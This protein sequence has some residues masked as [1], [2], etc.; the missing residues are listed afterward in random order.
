MTILEETMEI[1]KA[2]ASLLLDKV[3]VDDLVLGIF[4]TGVKL[5]TGHGGVAFTPVGEIPE[6]VCCP[7]TAARMPR[8]GSL[9]GIPVRDC[10]PFATEKNVLKSAIAV[11]AINAVTH[12]AL[13]SGIEVEG[14][15][16]TGEDGFDLLK[17]KPDEAIS[18]IGAFG[19]YIRR[20]KRMGNPFF[21]VE[22]NPLSLREEE[23]AF[24]RPESQMSQAL[25][26]SDVVIIT[27]TAIVNQTIDA[28]VGCL[29]KGSRAAV[30]GPTASMW[31]D[32]FFRRGI[33]VM[34]GI[35]ILNSDSMVRILKE[36]G[37]A[38]HLL[39]ECSEKI[40]FVR[41]VREP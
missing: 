36:G 15:I 8:A 37:S 5:S 31:P 3:T 38:Y 6:A 29:K 39:H 7:T 23:K 33:E 4:F 21:I 11:A 17:I 41:R 28:I 26:K 34:A 19:P 27:G 20:L 18:L 25:E 14:E 10:L 2:K 13:D 35:R 16:V 40:A 9:T 30:I 24:Y 22:R 32:A 12:L 1:L